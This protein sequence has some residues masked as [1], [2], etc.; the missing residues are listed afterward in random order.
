MNDDMSDMWRDDVD[1]FQRLADQDSD[2]GL[3]AY[4]ELGF[5]TLTGLTVVGWLI[6]LYLAPVDGPTWM[7]LGGLGL[8]LFGLPTALIY[9]LR[10]GGIELVRAVVREYT[11]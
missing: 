7:G 8:V 10:R 6:G 9:G 11:R 1:K 3:P 5:G 4:M 2:W